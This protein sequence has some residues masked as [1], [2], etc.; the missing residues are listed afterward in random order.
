M[1]GADFRIFVPKAG[2]FQFP[3]R[4][5]IFRQMDEFLTQS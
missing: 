5:D 1:Q 3:C 4:P 2:E